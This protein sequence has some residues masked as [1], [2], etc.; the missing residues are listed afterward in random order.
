MVFMSPKGRKREWAENTLSSSGEV[1]LR[2]PA[3][4][5]SRRWISGLGARG[6]AWSN[7]F[8]L[9][10]CGCFHCT[11]VAVMS[12]K[13]AL[14][15][16]QRNFQSYGDFNIMLRLLVPLGALSSICQRQ[17]QDLRWRATSLCTGEKGWDVAFTERQQ[18]G[19]PHRTAT[20]ATA[21]CSHRGMQ[22]GGRT[23][24]TFGTTARAESKYGLSTITPPWS[25]RRQEDA[26]RPFQLGI[27]KLKHYAAR[28]CFGQQLQFSP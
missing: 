11:C 10:V 18:F 20:H 13:G 7:I 19:N 8:V 28:R 26:S 21:S 16:A 5:L 9:G 15:S 14:F 23:A 1:D 12:G 24:W 4:C 17:T 3:V 27:V 25:R 6:C 22:V 2:P